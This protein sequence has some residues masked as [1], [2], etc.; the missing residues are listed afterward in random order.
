M[1]SCQPRAQV[2]DPLRSP[3]LAKQVSALHGLEQMW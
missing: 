3:I 1:E 2:Q